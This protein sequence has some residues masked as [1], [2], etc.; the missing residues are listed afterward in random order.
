MLIYK[1]LIDFASRIAQGAS[2]EIEFPITESPPGRLM[3]LFL[4]SSKSQAGNSILA[5]F[6]TMVLEEK[7]QL[8]QRTMDALA[9]ACK[10]LCYLQRGHPHDFSE[11]Y[12]VALKARRSYPKIAPAVSKSIVC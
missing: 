5:S 11:L 9:I 12:K 3:A 4:R 7:M 1:G 8:L 2:P 10:L 6:P